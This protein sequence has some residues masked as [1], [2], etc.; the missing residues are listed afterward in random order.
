MRRRYQQLFTTLL[1]LTFSL[2][3][4][5]QKENIRDYTEE[6]PLVYEDAWDLWPYSFLNENGK[7]DGFRDVLQIKLLIINKLLL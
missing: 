4:V 3:A 6:H 5:A 7:P 2:S 1:L